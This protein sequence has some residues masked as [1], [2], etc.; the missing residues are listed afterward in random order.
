MSFF[1]FK[2]KKLANYAL[3]IGHA[4][5]FLRKSHTEAHK[6]YFL[7]EQSTASV[8]LCHPHKKTWPQ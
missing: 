6:Q 1:L 5:W 4:K 2:G 8:A 7:M 3:F